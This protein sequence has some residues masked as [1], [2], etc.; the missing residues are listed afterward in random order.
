MVRE[1]SS[2]ALGS[3]QNVKTDERTLSSPL[4]QPTQT[5]QASQAGAIHSINL[6]I[7]LSCVHIGICTGNGDSS[8]ASLHHSLLLATAADTSSPASPG[9]LSVFICSYSTS[10][11]VATNLT[12]YLYRLSSLARASSHV[13]FDLSLS[14]CRLPWSRMSAPSIIT[15][16]RSRDCLHY[17]CHHEPTYT[18]TYLLD[19]G[20]L[21]TRTVRERVY[22][23]SVVHKYDT[24][25]PHEE[26]MEEAEDA[27]AAHQ[28]QQQQQ[29]TLWRSLTPPPPTTLLNRQPS[30]TL[31]PLSSLA[32]SHQSQ[33]QSGSSSHLSIL[34]STFPSSTVVVESHSE[35]PLHSNMCGGWRAEGG[36]VSRLARKVR[37][38][39]LLDVL[40]LPKVLWRLILEYSGDIYEAAEAHVC[41]H[42]LE[43]CRW[44]GKH[45]IV[46]SPPMSQWMAT[47]CSD[48]AKSLV[49]HS[50]YQ[51][52]DTTGAGWSHHYF[53]RASA[54]PVPASSSSVLH[55]CTPSTLVLTRTSVEAYRKYYQPN[56]LEH[57]SYSR[58]PFQLPPV[59]GYIQ[60]LAVEI[61]LPM[62]ALKAGEE[63]G[64]DEAEGTMGLSG[65]SPTLSVAST[66]TQTPD[67]ISPRSSLSH[68]PSSS[69]T[70]SARHSFSAT[71]FASSPTDTSA[72][73][74]FY[75]PDSLHPAFSPRRASL[76]IYSSSSST[77]M[78]P[79]SIPYPSASALLS[80]SQLPTDVLFSSTWTL[81]NTLHRHAVKS[82]MSEFLQC[83]VPK[84]VCPWR[85][86]SKVE[87]AFAFVPSDAQPLACVILHK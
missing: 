41:T 62:A 42:E 16:L 30:Y 26:A 83:D 84:G 58:P 59:Q 34:C 37:T 1:C 70:H 75:D 15:H 19:S 9:R 8:N 35:Q 28:Q 18:E 24:Q 72:V 46:P 31:A 45:D 50:R 22:S 57:Y 20:E 61:D 49:E 86:V 77:S 3:D 67:S 40:P 11:S 78:Q 74:S 21:H 25:P 73:A 43:L 29:M 79:S 76:P 87:F 71:A 65:M 17:Q 81:N 51:Q 68:S 64:M 44:K 5:S 4:A 39:Q 47:V 33:S 80:S 63:R 10:F 85:S 60:R 32:S 6:S 66:N 36:Y 2:R 7:A 14:A 13:S 56:V 55:P 82:L 54:S 69:P 23:T 52:F 53:L 12:V 48:R 38:D 27:P